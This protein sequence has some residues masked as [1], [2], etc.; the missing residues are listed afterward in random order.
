MQA[1][2][3]RFR[4]LSSDDVPAVVDLYNRAFAPGDA[5]FVPRRASW[6]LWKYAANPAGARHIVAEN[7]EGLLIAHY[8]GVPLAVR[9]DGED[10]T[11][12]QN[13]D[14][15]S[16]PVA[17]RGLKNPGT[18]VRLA[19]TYASTYAGGAGDP[20][21]YGFGNRAA[22][23]LGS[24][25]LDYRMLRTQPQ[26]VCRSAARLPDWDPA[27]HAAPAPSFDAGADAFATAAER[28]YRCVGRRDAAFLNWRFRDHPETKYS[29]AI[30]KSGDADDHRGHVVYRAGEFGGRRRGLIMDWFVDPADDG[31]A[32]SLLR[33]A[34]ERGTRD[35]VDDLAF[36]CPVASPWFDRFQRWGFEAEASSYVMCARSYDARF[37]V[38]YLRDHWWYTLADFDV[39]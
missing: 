36:V 9:A 18:I 14:C 27:T 7:D 12:S 1:P 21:M 8:G 4:T 28:A 2:G 19:Q 29:A 11:F 25:Y 31:A 30:A 26:L 3:C 16:D 22:Y 37:P 35:G 39:V 17:R 24:R 20:V 15:F 23:R 38:G 32:R 33:W 6:F 10:A 13:C 34:V 5:G